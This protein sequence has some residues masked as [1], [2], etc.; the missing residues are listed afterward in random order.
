LLAVVV[1][2]VGLLIYMNVK[3]R[4]VVPSVDLHTHKSCAYCNEEIAI[5]AVV[6]KY[7][8]GVVVN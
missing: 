5:D 8:R 3:K 4:K 7:C 6:C 1:V 2:V